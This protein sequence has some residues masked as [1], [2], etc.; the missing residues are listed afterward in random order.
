M[1]QLGRPVSQGNKIMGSSTSKESNAQAP[2]A[3]GGG[4][5]VMKK[6][7]PQQ[8]DTCPVK[9]KNQSVFNVYGQKIDPR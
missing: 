6:S 3:T 9:Y 5:P 7:E 8:G 4:C 1:T 2:P